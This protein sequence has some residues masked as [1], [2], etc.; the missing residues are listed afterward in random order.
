M[1]LLFFDLGENKEQAFGGGSDMTEQKNRRDFIKASGAGVAALAAASRAGGTDADR[2]NV[3]WLVSED[4]SPLLGCYGDA[5]ADT[6]HLDRMAREGV[7]FDNAFA[8]TPVCAPARCTIHTGMYASSLGT[9]HMRSGNPLPS[10]A[11]FFTASL[12]DAGYFCT[13]HFRTD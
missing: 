11:R 13:N 8:N 10:F 12:R 5:Y 9:E 4:N 2:P 7:V 6:P 1:E 3:L